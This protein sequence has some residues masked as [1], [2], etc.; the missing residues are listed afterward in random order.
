VRPAAY[1]PTRQAVDGDGDFIVYFQWR[2]TC[3][4]VASIDVADLPDVT[5]IKNHLNCANATCVETAC[6][7]RQRRRSAK[8]TTLDSGKGYQQC[9]LL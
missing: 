1:L 4:L 2:P 9:C 5:G 8:A 7:K 3:M 6:Y